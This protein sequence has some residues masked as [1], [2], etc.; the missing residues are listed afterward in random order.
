LK[1]KNGISV[2]AHTVYKNKKGNKVPGASTIAGLLDKPGLHYWANKL[3]LDGIEL[4]KYLLDKAAIGTLCHSFILSWLEHTGIDT[5][6][7]T[8]QQ[9]DIA[10][11]SFHKYLDWEKQHK[12]EPLLLETP[13]VSEIYQY[14]GTPDNYCLLDNIPTYIDYKTSNK[15]YEEMFIQASAYRQLLEENGHE[16]ERIYLLRIGREETEGFEIQEILDTSLYFEIFKHCLDIY[17]LRKRIKK[18]K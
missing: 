3:G 8:K 12:L 9:I 13:L 18:E 7:Y 6:I 1:T 2:K 10:E 14:G 11:T 16:V 15:I 4:N 17:N 5:S